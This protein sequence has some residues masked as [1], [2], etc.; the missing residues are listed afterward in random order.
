MTRRTPRSSWRA[1]GWG[2]STR[3]ALAHPRNQQADLPT[4]DPGDHTGQIRSLTRNG[5]FKLG[6]IAP[7]TPIRTCRR[8]R[9]C[10]VQ[11]PNPIQANTV[12]PD[13]R[14]QETPKCYGTFR[15]TGD[16]SP[17][18]ILT[19]WIRTEGTRPGSHQ[20]CT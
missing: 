2:M 3:S 7:H 16:R 11:S 20:H 6:V 5:L 10:V 9:H 4:E 12:L 13:C 18:G 1:L 19:G 15:I 8:S 14:Q 17:I